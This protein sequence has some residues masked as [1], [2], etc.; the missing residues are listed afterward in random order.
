[1]FKKHICPQYGAKF[2]FMQDLSKA[3]KQGFKIYKV[4]NTLGS[5]E[6]FDLDL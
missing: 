1:M 5:N 4:D 2:R 3:S 6:W